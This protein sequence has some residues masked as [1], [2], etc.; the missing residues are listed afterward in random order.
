M[1]G[2]AEISQVLLNCTLAMVRIPR[3]RA[4]FQFSHG[5]RTRPD[6]RDR[7]L[8]HPCVHAAAVDRLIP[9]AHAQKSNVVGQQRNQFRR[10]LAGPAPIPGDHV[11]AGAR[12]P[13]ALAER[14]V[15]FPQRLPTLATR[16]ARA[17]LRRRRFRPPRAAVR[18]AVGVILRHRN[19]E[20]AAQ[21]GDSF[22]Y[23]GQAVRQP[24]AHHRRAGAHGLDALRESAS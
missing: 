14:A 3:L 11:G 9:L 23:V 10:H 16:A 2:T 5:A 24:L 20:D 12:S 21:A 15:Q 6:H 18:E 8:A 17:T 7:V 4:N 22:E 1:Y 13:H 19:A